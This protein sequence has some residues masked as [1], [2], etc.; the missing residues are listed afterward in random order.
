MKKAVRTAVSLLLVFALCAVI[1]DPSVLHKAIDCA[2]TTR[3]TRANLQW[4]EEAEQNGASLQSFEDTLYYAQTDAQ[5]IVYLSDDIG[6]VRNEILVAFEDSTSV[7]EKQKLFDSLHASVVGCADVVNQYQLRIA[8]QRFLKL[9]NICTSLQ[10]NKNVAFASCNMVFPHTEDY[11]YDDPWTRQGDDYSEA[12][13]WEDDDLDGGN[14]WLTATQT[15]AAWDYR[16]YFKPIHVGVLDSG[17]ET[18][19]E[20]LQGKITFPAKKY[21]KT[22]IPA[23]HGT[24]VAGIISAIGGNQKGIAG[25]CQNANLICVDWK[26]EDGQTWSSQMRIYTGIIAL[27]KA[28]AKVINLSLGSSSGYKKSTDFF[29]RMGMNLD[30]MVYSYLIASLLHKGYDF[31]VVQSAGNG[32]KFGTPCDTFLNGTFCAI[33]EKNC[34]TGLTGITKQE[35]F[36]HIL[37]IGSS[38]FAHEGTDFYM[39]SFSNY[40]ESVSIFAPGSWVFSTD[41]TES[42]GYST[43]SGTSM[44]APV[45]TAI[46]AMTWSVNPN[47]SAAEVK[48]IV[49]DPQNT[50]YNCVNYYNLPD[51]NRAGI[52]IPDCPMINAKLCVEA[53]IRTLPESEQPTTEHETEIEIETTVQANAEQKPSLGKSNQQIVEKFRGELG[54]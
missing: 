45:A 8:P 32:N 12:Y 14:W 6:Y 5:D 35:V 37:I 9:Q 30:G 44:S 39:S 2:Q 4:K 41:L 19:H 42:G 29:W 51:E 3:Q 22:N 16:E 38:T 13:G 52:D 10:R 33:T 21:E 54:E 18:E 11:V 46:T 17:F 34:F 7:A 49:C 28:G 26:P 24:H 20:D 31:L 36:D 53:A 27:V 1:L 25:I 15:P 43:K 47:L 50:I 48:K 23:T 40:G